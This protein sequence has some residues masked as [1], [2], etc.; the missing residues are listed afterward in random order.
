MTNAEFHGGTRR[1]SFFNELEL[2]E[3]TDGK[4]AT[5]TIQ[6]GSIQKNTINITGNSA[7]YGGGLAANGGIDIGK[8]D[9]LMDI[10]IEKV[11]SDKEYQDGI[12]P[13]SVTVK[14][15]L[16]GNEVDSLKLSADKVRPDSITF[17]LLAMARRLTARL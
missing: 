13:E 9:E 1:C 8:D 7:A 12:P 6:G 5:L 17:N 2:T 11:W 14:L 15:M 16:N 10:P 4:K 3:D